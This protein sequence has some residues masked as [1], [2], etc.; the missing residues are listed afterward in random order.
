MARLETTAENIARDIS[1][2]RFPE[3]SHP[4][5]VNGDTPC[6]PQNYRGWEIHH[7][8]TWMPIRAGCEFDAY[9]GGVDLDAKR[10]CGRTLSEV[11]DE[12]NDHEDGAA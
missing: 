7:N 2:G 8:T 4:Q 1:E 3:R 6:C 12:I 9:K 10:I 11:V 5:V